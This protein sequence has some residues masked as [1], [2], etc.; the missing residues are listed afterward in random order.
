M[1]TATGQRAELD[2]LT[3][4]ALE[5]S[6]EGHYER[7]IAICDSL[8]EKEALQGYDTLL[9][10]VY[11]IMDASF[12]WLKNFK[13]A[14]HYNRLAEQAYLKIKDSVRLFNT[15]FNRSG[16]AYEFRD[17]AAAL[18]YFA[19]ASR[20]A[21]EL[22]LPEKIPLLKHARGL[23]LQRLVSM[24]SAKNYYNQNLDFRP[25]EDYSLFIYNNIA[26]F[27]LLDSAEALRYGPR[28]L[29]RCR[30]MD[31]LFKPQW[32]EY[33]L[34]M[35]TLGYCRFEAWNRA[36]QALTDWAEVLLSLPPRASHRKQFYAC[37]ARIAAQQKDFAKA[38]HAQDSVLY[39]QAL[40]DS[41]DNQAVYRRQLMAFEVDK[42]RQKASLLAENL[43]R[44][45]GYGRIVTVVSG[46]V[47]LFML[48]SL[49]FFG[50]SRQKTRQLAQL[51]SDR[52]EM[53][54]IL[55]HDMRTPLG[56][57]ES[58]LSLAE[59]G[60]VDAREWQALIPQLKASLQSAQNTLE[61]V[62]GWIRLNRKNLGVQK[63][64]VQIPEIFASIK[65]SFST[66]LEKKGL[67]LKDQIE[68][69]ELPSDAFLLETI[70]RNL[71]G[72][73]I[74]FSHPGGE[75]SVSAVRQNQGWLIAVSD[76][77]EG[78]EAE[79]LA[80]IRQNLSHTRTGTAREK[81]SGL[82]LSIVREAA[83]RLGAKVTFQSQKAKGTRVEI[84]IP[85]A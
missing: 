78:I 2:T 22:P 84:F 4:E 8:L 33:V 63:E 43:A 23:L 83:R 69:S 57:V 20:I 27:N 15:Y 11:G 64:P 26:Y 74:K 3:R 37:Q 71:I 52:E 9:A 48:I 7:A 34:R 73:A 67:K 1:A 65:R 81:G 29:A 68:A 24:D 31:S 5:E 12:A 6:Q 76:Q 55:S 10:R 70:L 32:E 54:A 42:R 66:S 45:E 56:Q 39:Y 21:R 80:R 40:A 58:V 85:Q 14:L 61:S 50:Q 49:Y 19:Q 51:S 53:L 28:I 62:L 25:G 35:L 77:G 36:E 47:F 79:A 38:Y 59:T 17:T 44:S 46:V 18:A 41:I 16:Y 30:A 75:I 60:A 13:E 72:N 82:G